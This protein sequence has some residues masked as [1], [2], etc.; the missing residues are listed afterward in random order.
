MEPQKSRTRQIIEEGI[1]IVRIINNDKVTVYA[2][3][4]SF[5]VIISVVPFLSLLISFI[6]LFIPADWQNAFAQ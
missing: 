5:F 2:A 6:S 4:A 3:Q 1:R